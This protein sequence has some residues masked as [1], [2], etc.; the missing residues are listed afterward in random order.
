MSEYELNERTK[1]FRSKGS[2]VQGSRP[3]GK[4]MKFIKFIENEYECSGLC[5]PSMFYL[6][7]SI[8]KG[9]PK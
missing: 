8:K 6:T 2:A 3:S 4:Y 7:Q 1:R 5:Y 9:P